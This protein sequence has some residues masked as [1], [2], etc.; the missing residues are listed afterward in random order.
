MHK[1]LKFLV[2]KRVIILAILGVSVY[3]AVSHYHM[4]LW[5]VLLVGAL[6]GVIFGKVFCRWVCP[7]GLIMELFMSMSPDGKVKQMYQYHKLGC[8]IAWISGWLNRI[9]LF[10][11]K[12]N[13]DTCKSCG[14]CD[15]QCYIVAME[16]AKYS[17]YKP[18]MKKPGISYTCSKCLLCVTSCPNDSLKYKI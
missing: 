11:I 14:I 18:Q 7:L 6:L 12:L 13:I 17:M 4:S 9:S 3:L 5:L 16:P 10:R 2:S 15:K 8:P 1:V